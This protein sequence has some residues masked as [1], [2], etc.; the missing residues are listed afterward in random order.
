M[1]TALRDA[2]AVEVAEQLAHAYAAAEPEIVLMYIEDEEREY[3]A[4]GYEPATAS[5][6]TTCGRRPR[7]LPWRAIGR[8]TRGNRPAAGRDQRLR[9]L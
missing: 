2:P 9:S 4:K 8:G 6:M 7:A 1:S 3:K 5:G